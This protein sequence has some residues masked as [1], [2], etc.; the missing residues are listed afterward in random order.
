MLNRNIFYG[1]ANSQM[2][3]VKYM[4][5]LVKAIVHAMYKC[6]EYQVQEDPQWIL[7]HNIP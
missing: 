5:Q 6:L 4:V 2:N 3:H 7:H 1:D